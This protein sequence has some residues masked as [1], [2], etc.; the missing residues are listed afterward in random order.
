MGKNRRRS[1]SREVWWKR[2]VGGM[3]VWL[4]AI[5][6]AVILGGLGVAAVVGLTRESPAIAGQE[7]TPA[8]P[9]APT[10]TPDIGPLTA[11]FIGDSYTAGAGSTGSGGF[12][13]AVADAND[14]HA[15]NL[16]AGGTG[17]ITSAHPQDPQAARA[18][19]G[20][21]HCPSFAEVIPDAVEARADIV[22]VSGGRNNATLD[23]EIAA[24]AINDFY[25]DLRAALPDARI[26]VVSPIW[27]DDPAPASMG[28]LRAAVQQAAANVGAEY[29]DIGE[30]LFGDPGLVVADGVH[31]NDAGYQRIADA[32]LAALP[33]S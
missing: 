32:I 16:A 17:Y 9:T 18:A 25:S 20:R 6:L 13:R 15:V 7:Q 10:A 14:W 28:G 21:D 2:N 26:I 29:I 1:K 5:S 4:T 22:F 8:E 11:V 33:A 27:D 24:D 30:P 23:T 31:P 3:P 12:V 19:C